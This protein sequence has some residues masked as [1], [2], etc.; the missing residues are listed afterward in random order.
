MHNILYRGG[1][2]NFLVLNLISSNGK[3]QFPK[4]FCARFLYISSLIM[5]TVISSYFPNLLVWML[6]FNEDLTMKGFF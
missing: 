3:W 5:D 2:S 6:D 1:V 4:A